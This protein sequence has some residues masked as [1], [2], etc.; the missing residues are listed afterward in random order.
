MIGERLSW[1]KVASHLGRTVTEIQSLMTYTELTDW[2]YY[3]QEDQTRTTITHHYLA[4]IASQIAKNRVKDPAKIKRE[5]FI[6]KVVTTG[7]MERMHQSKSA[8]GAA[9]G[10]NLT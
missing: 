6:L 3:I 2:L 4:E 5:L 10:V 1:F 8:W 9:T 7:E